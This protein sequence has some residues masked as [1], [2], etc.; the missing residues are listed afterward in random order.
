MP[1]IVS[2]HRTA[3]KN[4]YAEN[5]RNKK[6]RR[7]FY[8]KSERA[9]RYLQQA[10]SLNYLTIF[11][12]GKQKDSKENKRKVRLYQSTAINIEFDFRYSKHRREKFIRNPQI[13]V[14]NNFIEK[15]KAATQQ[16]IDKNIKSLARLT[17]I[18]KKE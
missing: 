8:I 7:Y 2:A 17:L 18:A 6:K 9:R 3:F 16:D 1:V 11:L 14:K 15:I 12:G 13:C 4:N 5:E 10:F